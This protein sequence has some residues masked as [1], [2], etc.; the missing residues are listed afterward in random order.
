MEMGHKSSVAEVE[1]GKKQTTKAPA[2]C[3]GLWLI[4]ADSSVSTGEDAEHEV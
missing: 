3:R 4:P 1:G 2:Y